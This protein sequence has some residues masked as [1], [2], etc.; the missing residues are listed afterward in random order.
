M[1]DTGPLNTPNAREILTVVQQRVDQCLP[2]V[3]G[4]WMHDHAGRFVHDEK[5]FVFMQYREGDG[6]CNAKR[7][8]RGWNFD[9]NPLKR[10][11]AVRGF[12]LPLIHPDG[13]ASNQLL[14]LVA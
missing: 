3:A 5:V 2:L 6:F 13:T 8:S 11:E 9:E 12:Y 4:R 10:P 14:D 1:H 7:R